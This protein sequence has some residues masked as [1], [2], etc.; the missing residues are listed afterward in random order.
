[1]F[2]RPMVR[3]HFELR[4]GGPQTNRSFGCALIIVIATYHIHLINQNRFIL[5]NHF[6]IYLRSRSR[7]TLFAY[8]ASLIQKSFL[9]ALIKFNLWMNFR[10]ICHL[11]LIHWYSWFYLEVPFPGNGFW[12]WIWAH[13]TFS[14]RL[15]NNWRFDFALI[16]RISSFILN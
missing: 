9:N 14:G 13:S 4:P 10:I 3:C 7:P 6:I 11:T 16:W 15:A 5:L 2:I 12:P 8:L 1:L